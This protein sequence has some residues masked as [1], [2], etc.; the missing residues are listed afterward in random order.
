MRNELLVFSLV[1]VS[2]GAPV[3]GEPDLEPSSMRERLATQTRLFVS[4]SDSAATI[5]AKRRTPTGWAQSLVH[6]A[7]EGGA[8]VA[9]AAE[10]GNITLHEIELG[11]QAV[12]IP[13]TVFGREAQ[14]TNL[15]LGLIA[16]AH[17]TATWNGDDEALATAALDLVL[18]WSLSADDTQLALGSPKLPPLPT[19][20]ALTGDGRRVTTEL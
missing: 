20:L 10:D 14:L 17:V 11:F 9:S 8:L 18:T 1:L 3:P 13:P 7:L 5:T 16:P 6:L 2:C 19:R 12:T 15:H 4:T